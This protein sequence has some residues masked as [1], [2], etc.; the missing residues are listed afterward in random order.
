MAYVFHGFGASGDLPPSDPNNTNGVI[1]R[2]LDASRT[3][4]FAVTPVNMQFYPCSPG[5]VSIRFNDPK[6]SAAN[7]RVATSYIENAVASGLAVLVVPNLDPNAGREIIITQP[8]AQFVHSVANTKKPPMY[9][10]AA[11]WQWWWPLKPRNWNQ[12]L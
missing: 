6:G 8:C 1:W 3:A 9:Q 5:T 12:P 2:Q 4:S 10:N 7:V 11:P